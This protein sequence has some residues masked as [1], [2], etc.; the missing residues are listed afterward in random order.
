M[1]EDLRY[2]VGKFAPQ[3]SLSD[4]DRIACIDEIAA[5]PSSLTLAVDG[6][7]DAQLDTPYRDGGWTVR[8]VVHHLADSHANAYI[9]MKLAA[10]EE[11]PLIKAYDEQVWSDQADA[12][13]A[14][15]SL[16]LDLIDALH[17]RWTWWMRSLPTDVFNRGLRHPESG[18]LTVD[19]LLQLYAW[20]GRHH[21][22]HITGVAGRNKW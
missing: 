5:L 22:A 8:Q 18:T 9:R 21:L 1:S 6:L 12:K 14:P 19:K 7:T 17:G 3:R 11:D 16:S 13:A 2:P 10:T 4:V 15:V 20:H